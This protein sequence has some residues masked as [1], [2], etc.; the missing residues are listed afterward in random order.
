LGIREGE[1]WGGRP[2]RKNKPLSVNEKL[3]WGRWAISLFAFERRE[4]NEMPTS[5][6]RV[7]PMFQ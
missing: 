3:G 6:L 4:L 1:N 2:F 5:S 7:G